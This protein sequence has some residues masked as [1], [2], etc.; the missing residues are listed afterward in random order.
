MIDLGQYAFPILASYGASLALLGA[1]ILLSIR[2]QR[3]T[4]AAIR[5]LEKEE[6]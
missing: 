5:V 3:K 6:K 1:I 4:R 2:D